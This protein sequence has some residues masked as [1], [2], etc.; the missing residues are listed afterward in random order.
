M[1]VGGGCVR[2]HMRVHA[3]CTG[4]QRVERDIMAI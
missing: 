3:S 1:C 4:E 2:G